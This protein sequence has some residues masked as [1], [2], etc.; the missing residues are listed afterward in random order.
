M[1]TQMKM[2]IEQNMVDG[3]TRAEL[4]FTLNVDQIDDSN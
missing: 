3:Q 2:S 4:L 1:E